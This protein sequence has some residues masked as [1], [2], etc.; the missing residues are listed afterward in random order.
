M[1]VLLVIFLIAS[2]AVLFG[3]NHFIG[4]R[5]GPNVS[6]VNSDGFPHES[7]NRT[8]FHMGVTY[9]Y[10]FKSR[11]GLGADLL[12]FQRGFG[13]TGIYTDELGNPIGELPETA[14]NYSYLSMPIKAGTSFGKEISGFMNIGIVPSILIEAKHIDPGLDGFFEPMTIDVTDQVKKMD[15]AGLF[16]MGGTYRFKDRLFF[17]ASIVYQYSFSSLTT[18]IMIWGH[19]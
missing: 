3:Q 1:K 18:S 16:E 13:I 17:Y 10:E 19:K 2:A 14:F 15:F 5:S 9:E 4:L 8:G 12:Y 6:N 7:E 11:L